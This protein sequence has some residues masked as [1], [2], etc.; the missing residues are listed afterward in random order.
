MYT[1]EHYILEELNFPV[2]H[3]LRKICQTFALETNLHLADLWPGESCFMKSFG[4][5]Y[6][7]KLSSSKI[8]CYSI[9]SYSIVSYSKV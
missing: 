4:M 6:S 9:I 1:V 5:T 3:E 7:L 8:K 2:F